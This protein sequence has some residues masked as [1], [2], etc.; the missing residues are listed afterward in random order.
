MKILVVDNYDSFAHNL[1]RYFRLAGADTDIVRNDED[2]TGYLKTHAPAGVVLSPGPNAP[3]QAGG[4][5]ALLKALP[6]SVPL[7]GVCLGHQCLVEAFGG[8]TM[9]AQKPMHGQASLARHDGQG[10]FEGAAHP[11][12]VGRYHSLISILPE[13]EG[14]GEG[15]E[16]QNGALIPCA[17]SEEGELMAVRHKARPWFGVQFHP[18]SILTPQGDLLTDNFLKIMRRQQE[19]DS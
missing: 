13:V 2:L 16:A 19:S 11:L 12:P 3:Q 18:E 4:C 5:L 17:W 7:F 9:R 1:A 14:A 6:A 15:E 8:K 10:L